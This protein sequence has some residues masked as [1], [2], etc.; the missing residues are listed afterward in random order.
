MTKF[1]KTM[2]AVGALMFAA[3]AAHAQIATQFTQT[4]SMLNASTFIQGQS[5]GATSCNTVSQTATQ[6]TITITP[7]AGLY[8]YITG[9]FMENSFDATGVTQTETVSTTNLTGAPFWNVGSALS[10]V[11]PNM[12]LANTFATPVKSTAAGTAVTFVPSAT[13]SAHNYLCMRVSG[14]YAQ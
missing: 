5:N 13:Q 11:G 6:D 8:V 1:L 12:V 4:G 9:V 14:F 7:P 2:T 3:S 10:T